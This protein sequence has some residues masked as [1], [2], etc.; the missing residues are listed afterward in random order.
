[1]PCPST[2]SGRD[3]SIVGESARLGEAWY[4]G[5]VILSWADVLD[6]SRQLGGGENLVWHEFAHQLDMLD[7]EIDGTPPLADRRNIASG[8]T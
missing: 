1:M 5:P 4:R 7:R 8:P 3:M 2:A 6:A